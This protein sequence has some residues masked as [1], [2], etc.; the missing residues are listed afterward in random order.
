M[1]PKYGRRYRRDY[2]ALL[3][4]RGIPPLSAHG[5]GPRLSLPPSF[6]LLFGFPS[7]LA[8]VCVSTASPVKFSEALNVAGIPI[9]AESAKV[10]EELLKAPQKVTTLK[11][12]SVKDVVP[13]IKEA[14]EKITNERSD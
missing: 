2:E 3:A 11:S 4:G 8:R 10:L 13:I 12:L 7:S 14:V 1:S 6:R 5:H 9:P